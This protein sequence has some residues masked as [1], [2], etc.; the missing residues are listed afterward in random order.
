MSI[1]PGDKTTFHDSSVKGV[2][3]CAEV[4]RQDKTAKAGFGS[5]SVFFIFPFS[6]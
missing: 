4:T 6:M 5:D 1:K 2:I 3:M